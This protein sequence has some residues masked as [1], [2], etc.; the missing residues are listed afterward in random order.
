MGGRLLSPQV[1]LRGSLTNTAALAGALE[2]I[3]ATVPA[4]VREQVLAEPVVG[5]SI[6]YPLGVTDMIAVIMLLRRVWNIDWECDAAESRLPGATKQH[7][8][9]TTIMI[10]HPSVHGST[11]QHVLDGRGWDVTFGRIRHDRQ[12]ALVDGHTRLHVG[13]LLSVVGPQKD[14]GAVAQ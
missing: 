3:Q 13:D 4:D 5:F 14:V 11:V 2:Y 8:Q 12:L 9:N 10:N 1:C 6:T 7:L